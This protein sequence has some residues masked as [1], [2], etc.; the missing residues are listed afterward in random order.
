MRVAEA[1]GRS[2]AQLGIDHVFGVVGSGNFHVT[3]A[4]VDAGARFVA[5]RHEGGA[6]TMADAYGRVSR[7]VAAVS[8]HQG[9]G[10]TNAL[11]GIT[12]AAKS[13]TPMLVLAAEA[14][15]PRSNFAVDQ[16]ALAEAVGAVPVRVSSPATALAD[17]ARAYHLALA[18]RR[19]VLLNLPLDVQA[20][21][22]PDDAL[23]P[24]AAPAPVAVEPSP[25][26][27]A[28]LAD[29]LARS[30]RP[31]FIAGRGA[32]LCRARESLLRLADRTGALLATSAVAKGFFQNHPWSLGI[33]GGFA[34]PLAA[35]LIAGAD[36]IVGWGCGLNM[37]TMRHG[38]LVGPDATVVQVDVEADAL[39]AHRP[40][41]LGVLGDVD[42]TARAVAD[43][44][45]ARGP[46]AG[47][48]RTA[49]L[50]ARIA[51][52]VG[53]HTVPYHDEGDGSRVD[54][55]SL[56]IRLDELLPAQRVLAVDSG[57]FMGYPSAYL[58]VP[59]DDGFCFTQAYQSIGLGLATAIGAALA[60]PDR[61]PVAACGDGGFLMSVAD[62][63]TVVRLRLPMLVVVYNDAAY[64]AEVH[65]FGPD[66]HPLSTVTF[67]D[68]DIAAI[69][70]G[71]GADAL[72]VRDV[73]DLDAVRQWLIGPRERPLVV[74]AKVTAERGA[75][76]LEEAFRGH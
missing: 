33:S 55:R 71:F 44:L 28:E 11:T 48:Y 8:V 66:G 10:L 50:R 14:T 24:A 30:R 3:N 69:A 72:T 20:A 38:K 68:T 61:M 45:A 43:E 42:R 54:A 76:W 63:E 13:R 23:A 17:A 74:D 56:S 27:I 41:D 75:W 16:P 47:G 5:A 19:T 21:Q 59:D 2:L 25:D 37:W 4:L 57:N 34:T 58:S 31:V 49:E 67:P 18:Q 26:A 1:V 29:L 62:L 36:L 70:R 73:R 64:G 65:H 39:G 7:R 32:R 53:A 51:V 35:E 22:L 6:A 12:E 9:C 15:E 60:A 46:A 40:V 52:E